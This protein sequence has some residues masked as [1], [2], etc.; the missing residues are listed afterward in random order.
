MFQ[1]REEALRRL[2]SQ[3]QEETPEDSV[4]PWETRYV[5]N[6]Q[7]Y[8]EELEQFY[9][10]NRNRRKARTPRKLLLAVLF[11]ILAN[12]CVAAWFYLKYKGI[13]P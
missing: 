7:L 11:L 2:D 9:T 10:Q 6:P 5:H 1:D 13:L 8:Q 4:S 12:L 3:L